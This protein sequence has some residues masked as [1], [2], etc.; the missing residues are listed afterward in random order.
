MEQ[1][2]IINIPT[3]DSIIYKQIL[4]FMNFLIGGTPQERDVLAELIILNHEYEA[5]PVDKRAKFILSTDMRKEMRAKLD[6]EEKQFNG[7]ILRLKKLSYLGEPV[8]T[9][10]GIVNE[11]LLFK[12]DKNGIQIHINMIM[13]RQ[14]M[15]R[16][17]EKPEVEEEPVKEETN[18]SHT[19][20]EGSE[21][22]QE[23]EETA[24]QTVAP[25]ANGD[26]LLGTSTSYSEDTVIGQQ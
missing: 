18:D 16:T 3:N 22:K 10:D 20:T 26:T 5:L 19:N 11:R 2:H 15:T 25:P 12:P 6:I 14:P 24:P 17:E 8:L 13:S 4:S 9:E 1:Q 23:P 7:L 21:E